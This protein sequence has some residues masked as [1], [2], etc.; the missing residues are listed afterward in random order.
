MT[1]NDFDKQ[2]SE[3]CI[4]DYL[5]N[6]VHSDKSSAVF[7]IATRQAIPDQDLFHISSNRNLRNQEGVDTDHGNATRQTNKY[8]AF[9]KT[10]LVG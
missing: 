7:V 10:R 5:K 1:A 2:Y 9:S 4:K 6:R 3:R 8:Q